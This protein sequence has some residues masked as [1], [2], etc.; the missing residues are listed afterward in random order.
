MSRLRMLQDGTDKIGE[1]I[2]WRDAFRPFI[3]D[4]RYSVWAMLALG[5]GVPLAS[6]GNFLPQIV[7]RLGYDTVK[8]NLYTVAPVSLL[9]IDLTIEHCRHRFPH[10][11]HPIFRLLPRARPAHCHSP[12]DHNGRIRYPRHHRRP[13]QHWRGVFCLF[14]ALHRQQHALCPARHLVFQQLHIRKQTRRVDR[15]HGWYCQRS[16][17]DLGQHLFS[18]RRAQ[19]HSCSRNLGRVWRLHSRR[20][21]RVRIVYAIREFVSKQGAG[22]TKGTWKQGC[23]NRVVGQGAE[24]AGVPVHVLVVASILHTCY[25]Y[26]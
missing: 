12:F 19:V 5:L 13:A 4:W 26:V 20:G 8:T 14:L 10:R 15:C 25:V 9:T 6:V 1:Q 23:A 11:F 17:L 16:G 22:A 3:S 21:W 2:D 7:A 24:G 18:Q